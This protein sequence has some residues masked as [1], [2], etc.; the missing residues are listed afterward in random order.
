[1]SILISLACFTTAVSVIVGTADFFKGLFKES[2]LAYTITAIVACLL[3][4][5]VGQFDVH[6]IIVVALPALMF[7]YPLTIVLILLNV[8]PEKYASKLV[9]KAVVLVTFI[10]SIPDFLGFL[11][12]AD[13]LESVK[14]IIPLANQN[15]GW[16][17]P[18]ITTFVLVNGL[19]KNT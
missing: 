14:E 12:E 11:V 15:L 2:Q 6:Y 13:W 4:V 3:G 5:L 1:L 17:L 8:I 10:F 19:R 16:V 7:I 9:F 18:A